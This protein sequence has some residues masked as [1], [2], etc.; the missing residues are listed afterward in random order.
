[1]DPRGRRFG[2]DP[3]TMRGWAELPQA[4][5]SID[6]DDSDGKHARSGFAQVCG[7]VSGT[8]R[9]E[10]IAQDSSNYSV[11]LA[12]RSKEV[13][14]GQRF[15][16]SRSKNVLNNIAIRKSTRD[17]IL[18]DNQIVPECWHGDWD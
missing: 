15:R 2:F 16:F 7:A 10:I 3:L 1:M 4:E 12:G 13:R 9:I 6:C 18:V 14:G 5:G 8:Y 17:V 11:A